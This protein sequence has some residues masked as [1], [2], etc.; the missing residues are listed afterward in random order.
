M[1]SYPSGFNPNAPSASRRYNYLLGGKDH[2]DPDRSSASEIADAIPTILTGVAENRK[3]VLR[4]VRHLATSLGVR[5][6]LDIGSGLPLSPMVHEVAQAITPDAHVVYVDNDPLVAS[7]SRALCVSSPQGR[8][9]FQE[10][11]LFAPD[12]VLNGDALRATLDLTRPVGVLICAVLHFEID[13]VLAYNA[14]RRLV[15]ALAPGSVIVLTHA[16]FDPLDA[17]PEIGDEHG[18]FRARS[19]VE[20][21]KFLDGLELIPPGL[22]STIRWHPNLDPAAEPYLTDADAICYAVAGKIP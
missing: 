21:A 18:P 7:H 16:T 19:A 13:D 1:T 14:V 11:D 9:D 2:F 10:G 12:A 3:L 4:A 6:F 22:V 17:V 8:V 15:G 5:Q 20:I